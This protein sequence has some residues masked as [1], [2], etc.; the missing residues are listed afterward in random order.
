M[1][2]K[3]E[4]QVTHAHDKFV[5][6]EMSDPR[7]ARDIMPYLRDI[8]ELMHNID[9]SGG[10]DYISIVLQYILERGELRDKRAFFELINK[11]ISPDVGEK[12]MSLAEQLKAEGS[13][14]G[15]V[16]EIQKNKIEI[17]ERLLAR[18]TELA[19][20]AEITGLSLEEIKDIHSKEAL[21]H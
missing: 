9:Q 3:S 20:I 21:S 14:E 16:E 15:Q 6:T 11:E 18:K 1:E 19:F 10:R 8:A 17:A 12:I 4:N 7:V 13:V 2:G 5:R